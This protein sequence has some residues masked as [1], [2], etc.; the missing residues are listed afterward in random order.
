MGGLR[1][2]QLSTVI[3]RLQMDNLWHV[4][5]EGRQYVTLAGAHGKGGRA[6]S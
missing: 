2:T 5:S 3:S 6:N 1:N 4:G